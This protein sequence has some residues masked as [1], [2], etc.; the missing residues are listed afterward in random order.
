[1]FP[2]TAEPV[3]ANAPRT[4]E[5]AMKKIKGNIFMFEPAAKLN[6]RW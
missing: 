5:T 6:I 1:M 3:A 4:T 2:S